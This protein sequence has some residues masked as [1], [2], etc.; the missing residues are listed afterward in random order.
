MCP[1]MILIL[2]S[3]DYTQGLDNP[4]DVKQKGLNKKVILTT[5]DYWLGF[6]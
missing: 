6:F 4:A 3:W 2:N 1:P 5:A